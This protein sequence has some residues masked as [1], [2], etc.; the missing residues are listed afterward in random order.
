MREM[1]NYLK[2]LGMTEYQARAMIVL[3]CKRKTIASNICKFGGIPKTKIY[4]VL[5]SLEDK[6]LVKYTYSSPREYEGIGAAKAMGK[7]I[8][9]HETMLK[10]MKEKKQETITQLRNLELRPVEYDRVH[11]MWSAEPYKL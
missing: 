8:E 2:T 10:H 11:P 7:L 5:K 1:I 4:Q 9:K 6:E 3:F